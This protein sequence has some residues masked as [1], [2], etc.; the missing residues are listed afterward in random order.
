MPRF[1]GIPVEASRPRF[2]GV[3]EQ[4]PAPQQPVDENG[5]P[6]NLPIPG[7]PTKPYVPPTAL[8]QVGS[9]LNAAQAGAMQGMTFGFNDEINAGLATPVVMGMQALSGKPVDPAAAYNEALA[10][11][12][13]TIE[14]AQAG[15]PEAAFVGDLAGS[16]GTGVKLANSGVTLLRGAKPS[17]G[18]IAPRAA[19]EGAV[20]GGVNGFGRGDTLQ[21]RLVG[22]GIGAGTGAALGFGSGVVGGKLAGS[23]YNRS[24]PT[25]DALKDA[26]SAAYKAVDNSGAVV[27]APAAKTIAD[28]ITSMSLSQ[29]IDPTIHPR[30][31]AALKRLQEFGAG[32]K[33]MQDVQLMR[34]IIGA[35]GKSPE[36]DERRIAG[37]MQNQLDDYLEQ[38]GPQDF[39]NGTPQAATDLAKGNDLYRTAKKTQLIEDTVQKAK[40]MAGPNYSASGYENALRQQFKNLLVSKTGLRGFS[41]AERAA[42]RQIAMGGPVENALRY[43]GRFAPTGN[44]SMMSGAVP[45]LAGTAAGNSGG[46]ALASL[47]LMGGGALARRLATGATLGNANLA[48]GLV[49][50]GGQAP[51]LS[52]RGLATL[53]GLIAAEGEQGPP[54]LQQGGLSLMRLLEAAR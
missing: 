25:S 3:P 23:A 9:A 47:G 26:A 46:G 7:S 49:A 17:I 38:L 8:E 41:K 54:S 13:Q 33:T 35:V 44:I 27:G 20:Y 15:N 12:R 18:S 5:Y 52:P 24:I 6:L 21:D 43:L 10:N 29:G 16:L 48:R 32:P 19:V 34:R 37:I 42:V 22:G 50:S 45:F 30:A 4:A 2:S 31:T 1:Q 11:N 51:R 40:D 28:D 53:E 14:E 36:A 39:T